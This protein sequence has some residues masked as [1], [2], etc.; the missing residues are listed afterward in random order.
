M[1]IKIWKTYIVDNYDSQIENGDIS[2]FIDKDYSGDL[3]EMESAGKIL[4]GINRLRNPI[5]Q[6]GED[7]QKIAMKYIQN[8]SKIAKLYFIGQ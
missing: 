1:I 2:F 4:D 3:Q 7:N 6:M 5:K 8:L